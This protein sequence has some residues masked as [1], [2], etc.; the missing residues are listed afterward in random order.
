[1]TNLIDLRKKF[2]KELSQLLS[3]FHNVHTYEELNNKLESVNQ[4]NHNFIKIYFVYCLVYQKFQMNPKNSFS[5][6]ENKMSKK[7]KEYLDQFK[8]KYFSK[9]SI[10][11]Y[12]EVKDIGLVK[13][14]DSH[15]QIKEDIQ[16]KNLELYYKNFIS[17]MYSN[18]NLKIS[19]FMKLDFTYLNLKYIVEDKSAKCLCGH[20]IKNV[21]HII[22]KNKYKTKLMKDPDYIILKIG[23]CCIERFIDGG[24]S[25][26][27]ECNKCFKNLKDKESGRNKNFK[28]LDNYILCNDCYFKEKCF[29]CGMIKSSDFHNEFLCKNT[30]KTETNTK[31]NLFKIREKEGNICEFKGCYEFC[32]KGKRCKI[33][34]KEY[35]C[36]LC[37]I[38]ID[39]RQYG[40]GKKCFDCNKKNKELLKNCK[41]GKIIKNPKFYQ[42]YNC[43]IE[44][45]GP[46]GP[47]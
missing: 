6:I 17:G 36:I 33:H 46:S 39:P 30:Y 45:I 18:S 35:Q 19:T 20:S 5:E 12:E 10:N 24:A 14:S 43:Y 23:N 9:I 28:Y 22:S 27:R 29:I 3:P 32:K 38:E 42:C 15:N 41:C 34:N 21:H 13:D 16:K 1:M 8:K 7:E 44:S 26:T 31:T 2:K 37:L 47:K 11:E 25:Y 40:F 4:K